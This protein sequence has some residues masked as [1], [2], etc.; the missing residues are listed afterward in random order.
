M[1]KIVKSVLGIIGNKKSEEQEL[2]TEELILREKIEKEFYYKTVLGIL[3]SAIFIIIVFLIAFFIAVEG[4]EETKV[5]YM[6]GVPLHNAIVSLQEKAL[7][8]KLILR[9]T[10]PNEKG[11]VI[12]QSI[13]GGAVVK[14]G[15]IIELTVSLG[16]VIDRVGDYTGKTLTG[17][18]GEFNKLFSTTTPVLFISDKNIYVDS[19]EP[20]GTILEQDPLPGTE[21]TEIT[22]IR[23]VISS[24]PKQLSYITPTIVG[25]DYLEALAK[26]TQ[27]PI[28]YRFSARTKKA[29][30]LPGTVITQSPDPLEEKPFSTVLEMTMTRPENYPS[31]MSFG[32]LE[33]VLEN[34]PVPVNLNVDGILENGEMVNRV[35][36]RTFGGVITIPY[37]EEIN[38]KLIISVNDEVIQEFTVR[39]K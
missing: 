39:P 17:L 34:Y 7:Y 10:V 36:S 1:K 22:E 20:F 37:L 23:L 25:M 6:Q 27:W 3:A 9:N 30:E 24:G 11:M 28:R 4:E 13:P 31:N 5:P 21:I 18:K 32:I 38:T 19:D 8:P 2:S 14:A 29:G 35:M 33:L 16:G 12:S 15:R 26:I